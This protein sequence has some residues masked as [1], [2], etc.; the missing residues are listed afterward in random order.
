MRSERELYDGI[1]TSDGDAALSYYA[2]AAPRLRLSR[3][4]AAARRLRPRTVLDLGCGDGVALERL[5]QELPDAALL[6]LDFSAVALGRVRGRGLDALLGDCASLPLRPAYAD[7]VVASEVLEHVADVP[8]AL[9]EA[10]RVL[11]PGGTLLI[12]VPV[13]D[14]FKCL[15]GMSDPAR[16]KYLDEQTHRREWAIRKFGKFGPL[17][18][19]LDELRDQGFAIKRRRGIFYWVWRFEPLADRATARW[20][21]AVPAMLAGEWPLSVVPGSRCMGKYLLIEAERS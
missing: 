9:A 18:A 10:R 3:L 19:L 8:A 7:L 2:K 5:R 12:T 16:V 20:P 13:A 1:A 4:A 14:W 6:G 11:K 17:S 15:A 21:L